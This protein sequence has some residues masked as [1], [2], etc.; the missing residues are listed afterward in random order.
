MS[1]AILNIAWQELTIIIAKEQKLKFIYACCTINI[2]VSCVVRLPSSISRP[3]GILP[4]VASTHSFDAQCTNS[5]VSLRQRYALIARSDLNTIENPRNGNGR[6]A[7]HNSTMNNRHFSVICWL[8]A[9]WERQDLW[10]NWKGSTSWGH[11]LL[12]MKLSGKTIFIN[13]IK[14]TGLRNISS[15]IHSTCQ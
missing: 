15:L 10:Y 11:F 14:I 13:K 9:K 8:I 6:I 4:T 5:L 1:R 12:I 7:L 3:A 2:K